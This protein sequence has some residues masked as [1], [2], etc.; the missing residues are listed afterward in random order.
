MRTVDDYLAL[1]TPYHRGKVNFSATVA[2]SVTC[3]ADDQVVMY[4]MAGDFDLDSAVGAQLDVVGQWVGVSRIIPVAVP[5]PYFSLDTFGLG[6]DQG[7]WQVPGGD[8]TE[9]QTLDDTSFRRLIRARIIAN[10]GDGTVPSAQAVMD[11]FFS[12]QTATLVFVEDDSNGIYQADPSWFGFDQEQHGFDRG[13]WFDATNESPII[14]SL[15]MA[16]IVGIAGII[17]PPV[18]LAILASALLP[19]NPAGVRFDI[20]VVSTDVEGGVTPV[21][22]IMG[23]SIAGM[24]QFSAFVLGG[25]GQSI[26]PSGD[27]NIVST[28]M[29]GFDMEN[30]YLSGFDV[31]AWGVS[32]EYLLN[33]I[34]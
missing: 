34:T 8:Q 26:A 28:P 23:S 21:P 19:I 11:E 2:A 32:P 4:G 20:L 24:A 12:G 15:G 7:T 17:P 14:E 29:F 5:N 13:Q 10:N 3:Q 25:L 18:D 6:F 1:I 33:H 31:G 30:E 27:E 9:F 16:M 22:S